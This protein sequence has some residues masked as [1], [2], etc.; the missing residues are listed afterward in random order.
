MPTELLSFSATFSVSSSL[1]FLPTTTG[2]VFHCGTTRLPNPP[3]THTGLVP[4]SLGTQLLANASNS[5]F[6][7]SPPLRPGVTT[8]C[9]PSPRTRITQTHESDSCSLFHLL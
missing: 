7:N 8:A 5:R 1:K 2:Q 4:T 3:K 9:F 6:F